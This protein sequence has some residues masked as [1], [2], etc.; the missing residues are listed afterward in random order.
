MNNYTIT[1]F[2]V[3]E[4]IGD[5][6]FSGNMVSGGTMTI[7]PN[8]G[9]VVTASDFSISEVPS[10]LASV[11]FTD[12][13]TAGQIGNK[14]TVTSTFVDNFSVAGNL[15]I[16]LNIVGDA[17]VFKKENQTINVG[18]RLVD[19]KNNNTFGSSIVSK[20]N[21]YIVE[22]TTE[23]GIDGKYDIFTNIITGSA[24]KSSVNKIGTITIT[25]D[26][27][28]FFNK[29]PYLKNINTKN[30]YLKQSAT[31][32]SDNKYIISYTFD[33]M[34]SSNT[35]VYIN[36]Q[37]PVF[38]VYSAIQIPTK[39]NEI[40]NVVLDRTEISDNG[41]DVKIKVYGNVDAT[42]D[43]AITK[44][45][46]EAYSVINSKTNRTYNIPTPAGV[47]KGVSAKI[48]RVR[49]DVENDHLISSFTFLQEFP[50]NIIRDTLLAGAMS[51]TAT[52]NV[53]DND[54]V[55]VGDRVLL[56][57]ISGGKTVK[58]TAVNPGSIDNRLTLSE[59]ITA[60]DDDQ[61]RFLRNETYNLNLYPRNST[62][63]G[64]KIS[65][66]KPHYT[67]KQYSNPILTLITTSSS[68]VNPSNV[69]YVGRANKSGRFLK[70]D[71]GAVGGTNA[72]ITNYSAK[73][74]FKITYSLAASSNNWRHK[75]TTLPK[76]SST[77]L[78]ASGF[79]NI[80]ASSWTNSVYATT[81]GGGGNEIAGNGG[82]H[83][84]IYNIT[85]AGI[86]S[87]T[88]TLTMDVLVK[89]WGTDD[90]TMTLDLD[91]AFYTA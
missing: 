18:V 54:D 71:Q 66:A 50:R 5:S 12:T 80:S 74:Y 91:A 16:K 33:I 88:L 21:N 10:Q 38:I 3:T 75:D 4:T 40:I 28:Y 60:A 68:G 78:D 67:I 31:T 14:I 34:F 62:V 25:A 70:D 77:C 11:V 42:F 37:Q 79:L 84:E 89:Q 59:A 48:P 13:T 19:N 29:K 58:V 6:V 30:V 8:A 39:K 46:D 72:T 23:V 69:F 45:T 9:H 61:V 81:K 2:K 52:M 51:D 73:N 22:S 82:T 32:K 24:I 76:W 87:G 26:S 63:L 47:I 90:V 15:K 53:D 35:D 44:S 65:I 1:T 41:G 43:L 20:F 86:G 17:K 36:D 85:V 27:D 56:N 7:T 57:K 64:P 49:T 55:A 83:I